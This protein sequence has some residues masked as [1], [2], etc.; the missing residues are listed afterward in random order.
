M[1]FQRGLRRRTPPPSA[2]PRLNRGRLPALLLAIALAIPLAAPA[3][4]PAA[5]PRTSLPAI[6]SQVMC[7]TCKIPLTIAESPQ[8]DRERAFIRSLIEQ[9]QSESQIKRALVGQYGSQVLA[10]PATHGFDLAAYLVPIAALVLVLSALALLLPRWRR[11]SRD[12]GSST[13][14]DE[15]P[16]SPSDTA[17]LE[18]D[19]ARFD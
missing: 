1:R 9:G 2:P 16:I 10:L 12:E 4:A 3:T 6:E 8:A 19:L 13:N 15:K 18:A 7:V 14:A 17:R 11:R 5:T